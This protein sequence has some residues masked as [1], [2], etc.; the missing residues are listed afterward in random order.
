[1]DE[2]FQTIIC[3]NY[4]VMTFQRS[5]VGSNFVCEKDSFLQIRSQISFYPKTQLSIIQ[6][7]A[8]L[9]YLNSICGAMLY[10]VNSH[11][12]LLHLPGYKNWSNE[13]MYIEQNFYCLLFVVC[14][15]QKTDHYTS[16]CTQKVT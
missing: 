9:R 16:L 12:L 11:F 6:R 8:D 2:K 13:M 3:N 1:M 10:Y 15:F 14:H 5:K 7:C 4:K